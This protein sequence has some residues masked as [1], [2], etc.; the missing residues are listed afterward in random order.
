MGVAI[1]GVVRAATNQFF[2][3]ETTRKKKN[4]SHY[5][6]VWNTSRAIATFLRKRDY[7][8]PRGHVKYLSER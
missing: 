3:E 7:G 6:R 8:K 1:V 4:C 5:S 2:G